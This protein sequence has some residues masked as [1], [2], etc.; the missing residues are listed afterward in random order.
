[1]KLLISAGEVS[2]DRLGA[3][4]IAEV[5]KRRPEAAFFGMGGARMAEEGLNRLIP[6][7]EVSVVGFFEV[8]SRLPAIARSL[9]R[10]VAAAREER[11]A[12]AVLIDF[13]DFHFRLGRRLS[14]LGIPVI[15]YVSPQVWAWRSGR[16]RTM[17]KFVRRMITLFPFE[18]EIY[19]RAGI[20]VVFAGHPI[21]DEVAAHLAE[22]QAKPQNGSK[23]RIVLMPG[24]RRAEVK[25]HW[26]V[27]REAAIRLGGRFRLES[28]VVPAP[29]LEPSLFEGAEAAGIEIFTGNVEA[30]LASCDLLLVASGTATL[31]AAL[32]G[33]PMV[34]IF[35]TSWATFLA[36]RPLI[37]VP[38]IA[39]PNLIAGE[40]IVPELVQAEANPSRISREAERLLS[41]PE[42]KLRIRERW[43]A[44]RG[45][46]GQP[47]AAARAARA[48]L[49]LLPA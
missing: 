25:R 23:K 49:E 19:R 4:L 9:R 18:T 21:A 29:G 40:R 17:K 42:A 6:A 14:R 5:R 38:H 10:L 12:A 20:D 24:S 41:S 43:T 34:V 3:S 39:L 30:L 1:M 27:M 22:V 44:L 33:A 35:R 32:C 26:P 46:M 11:P 15:Y 48:V 2:G 36:L 13:P 8:I 47:D 45:A 31:Q 37:R 16:V 7:E 28:V